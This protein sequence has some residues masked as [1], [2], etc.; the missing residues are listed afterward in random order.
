MSEL[1]SSGSIM[2]LASLTKQTDWNNYMREM[3]N[4]TLDVR[5]RMK[6][7]SD[8]KIAEAYE[9]LFTKCENSDHMLPAHG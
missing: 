6:I 5:R 3:V 4:T 9:S 1:P 2:N 7:K 8:G